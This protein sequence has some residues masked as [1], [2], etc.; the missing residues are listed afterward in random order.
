MEG[1][2]IEGRR[3]YKLFNDV[4]RLKKKAVEV[5]CEDTEQTN[6]ATF[7]AKMAFDQCQ[8]KSLKAPWLRT[9]GSWA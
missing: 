8:I 6:E 3:C 9:V 5:H 4:K 2:S 1:Y 7:M